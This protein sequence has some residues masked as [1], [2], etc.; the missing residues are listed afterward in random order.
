M[1]L[2]PNIR[3]TPTTKIPQLF[4]D[5]VYVH[6]QFATAHPHFNYNGFEPG[7]TV[8]KKGHVRSPGHRPFPTDVIFERDQGIRLR[9]G[10]TLY[11]DVF[12]PTDSDSTPVPV[13]IPWSPYGKTG[14]G[15]MNLDTMAP[16]R[17]GVPKSRTSGYEKWE[18]PDPAEW[19]DRGYAILSIDARGAGMSEG[20]IAMWGL[21]EAEDIYDVIEHISKQPWCNG[22]VAM[23]GNSWLAVSQVNF[24]ARL[25]HPALKAIAPWEA[26]TDLYRHFVARGGRRHIPKFHELIKGGLAGPAKLEFAPDMLAKRPMYDEYWEAKRI[27]VENINDIPMYVL[28]SHSSILHTEGSLSTWRDAK[29]AKKWLRVHP[30]QEWH[31]LYRDEVNDDLQRFFDRYCKGVQNGWEHDT[32]P[33]R[34]SLLGFEADGAAAQT[35]I[36]RPEQE[37]PLAREKPIQLYLDAKSG[38]LVQDPPSEENTTSYEAHS[39]TSSSDFT[40][41]F[42]TYTELA[43]WPKVTLF[44]SCAD[45]DDMDVCVQLRKVDATG[46]PLQH[47]N[48]P[49]PVPIHH[50]DDLNIAKTLGPQGFLRASH[51]VSLD[52][53]R[54]KGN[55]LFYSHQLR[56]PIRPGAVVELEI[57]IWPVGMVFAPGEGVMLRVSGHD[58]CLPE[59]GMCVLTEPEDENVGTHVVHTGGKYGS[60][61]TLPVIS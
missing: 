25:S 10:I 40:F 54:S 15:P 12:R 28:A 47:L 33:V 4:P 48:Y 36:E 14:T 42:T 32:P 21:Q 60:C 39:L 8:L 18:A 9:D 34:L 3:E 45:K 6:L 29:T 59:T 49:V 58:M 27:P 26:L 7:Q 19:C 1:S 37:Y 51:A 11:T 5:A 52:R 16:L 30:Y 20:D 23:A 50:V 56:E 38:T 35:V 22:S 43:G 61:L 57:P 55:D 31:D 24:A 2:D 53:S 17:A 13:V 41:H 44:M 46:R